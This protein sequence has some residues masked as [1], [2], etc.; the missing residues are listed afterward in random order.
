MAAAAE[1]AGVAGAAGTAGAAGSAYREKKAPTFAK[2]AATKT[3]ATGPT[4][5]TFV[6]AEQVRR[7]LTNMFRG[8]APWA[9]V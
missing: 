1:A 5:E 7:T 8:V 3:A 2:S 6:G 4:T 9:Y